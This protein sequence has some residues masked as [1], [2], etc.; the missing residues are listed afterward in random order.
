MRNIFDQYDQQENRLTHALICTLA[1]DK[2]L[3]PPFLR[4]LKGENIPPLKNIHIGQQ[5][6]PG[7]EAKV[8]KEGKGSIPDACFFDDEGWAL[9]IESKVQDKIRIGQLRRHRQT[10]ACYGYENAHVVLI[11]VDHPSKSQILPDGVHY[12]SW[13]A[14]YQWFVHR[15]KMSDWAGRL[16]EYMQV[17]EANMIDHDYNI[18]GTLTMFSGF[19]FDEEH[20]YTYREGKRLIRL[21]GQEFRK[22]KH[23]VRELG[24]DPEGQ[25]RKGIGKDEKIWDFIP[26]KKAEGKAFTAYPHATIFMSSKEAGVAITVPNA[27]KGWVKRCLKKIGTD[28]FGS[29][30]SKIEKNLQGCIKQSPGTRPIIYILQRQ[31]KGQKS[32]VKNGRLEVDLRTLVNDEKTGLKH[33]PMWLEA[34]YSILTHKRTNIQLGIEVRFPYS[35]KAMQS[36][37]ALDIMADAWIAMKPMLDFVMK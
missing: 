36:A 9:V 29:L 28:E 11:A 31:Y 24:L 2:K 5:Q 18:R 27:F 19:H 17:F 32:H 34:I 23:L 8:E 7:Q 15:S 33:Q 3:I 12:V 14:V 13:K 37:K 16:V 26:L 4:W 22:N 20:P 6:P 10:A 1:N 35:E 21:M 25:G 30:L